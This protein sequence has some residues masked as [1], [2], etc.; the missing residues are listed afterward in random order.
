MGH[1]ENYDPA[2]LDFI[3]TLTRTATSSSGNKTK[4]CWPL[5][6][7]EWAVGWPMDVESLVDYPPAGDALAPIG[8]ILEKALD[9]VTW[10]SG[11]DAGDLCP[12]HANQSLLDDSRARV[13]FSRTLHF[14]ELAS[15]KR[16][17][18]RDLFSLVSHVLVGHESMFVVNHQRV[19]PCE[20][21]TYHANKARGTGPEAILSAWSLAS[22]LYTHALFPKWPKLVDVAEKTRELKKS[23]AKLPLGFETFFSRNCE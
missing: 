19:P 18:F 15:G 13:Q 20:W 3:D 5:E 10:T 14:Y 11:C 16:W 1:T 8:Q 17:N 6:G 22:R 12:F 9:S 7:Y 2:T 4:A 21:S 23:G